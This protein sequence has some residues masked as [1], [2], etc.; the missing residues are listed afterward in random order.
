MRGAE[1]AAQCAEPGPCL[2]YTRER[3]GPEAAAELDRLITSLRKVSD[4]EL[5]ELL[6]R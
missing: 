2:A 3:Y 1:P 6:G 4:D 5:R